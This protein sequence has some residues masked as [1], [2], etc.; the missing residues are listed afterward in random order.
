[1]YV[2]VAVIGVSIGVGIVYG[3]I[4]WKKYQDDKGIAGWKDYD[5]S[6]VYVFR[7]VH[8]VSGLSFRFYRMLYSKLFNRVI[9]SMYVAD[10]TRL[11]I[12]TARLTYVS[13]I[14]NTLPMMALCAILLYKAEQIDQTFF[15]AIDTLILGFCSAVFLT[16]DSNKDS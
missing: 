16:I 13:L 7:A 1:M 11:L 3:V 12:T 14:V 9:F 5:V 8:I 6:C 10:G 15:C 4:V 2:S